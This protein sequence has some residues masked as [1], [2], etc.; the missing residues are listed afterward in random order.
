MGKRKTAV[1]VRELATNYIRLIG[2][3]RYGRIPAPEKDSSGDYLW[4]DEDITRA[5]LALARMR[6]LKQE[7]APHVCA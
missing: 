7:A 6:P 4:G 1:A 5:R 3:V 2:L